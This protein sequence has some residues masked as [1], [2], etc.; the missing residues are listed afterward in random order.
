MVILRKKLR[1]ML[2]MAKNRIKRGRSAR[3]GNMPS[4]Y[5]KYGKTPYRYSEEYR[6]WRLNKLRLNKLAGRAAVTSSKVST[7]INRPQVYREAAE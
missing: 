5:T 6:T 2:T 4:P 1:K 3:N 7:R